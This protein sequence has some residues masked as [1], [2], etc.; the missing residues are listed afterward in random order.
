MVTDKDYT[1]MRGMP[2]DFSSDEKTFGVDDQFMFGPSIMVCPVTD[3]MYHTPPQASEIISSEYFRTKDGL[4]GL[5]AKYYKDPA[6]T[7]LSRETIDPNINI[8]WYT[9]RPDYATDSTYAITWEGKLIPKET[10]KHQFH[11]IS[12]DPKRIILNGDTLRMVYTSTEQ[13]TEIVELESG[14]VYEF[15]LETENR[16]TGAAKMQLHWKTPS[17]F[18]KELINDEKE[19]TRAVYLPADHMWFDFWTGATFEGGKVK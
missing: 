7:I 8:F 16:S 13:Y 2:M 10:G 6:R 9:G 11:L 14:K 15:I 18:A 19:T 17:I 12:Y 4:Q 1:I 5:N 3:Y